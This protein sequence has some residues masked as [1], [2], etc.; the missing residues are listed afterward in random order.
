[1][2]IIRK[3]LGTLLTGVMASVVLMGT[4]ALAASP[5]GGVMPR[6]SGQDTG[7]YSKLEVSCN[8]E[9]ASVKYKN[10]AGKTCY[11]EVIGYLED[12]YGNE[13]PE[14]QALF[15]SGKISS[16]SSVADNVQRSDVF[17]VNSSGNIYNGES[18][19]SPRYERLN[20]TIRR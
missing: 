10:N 15:D 8:S 1:M 5:G 11:L 7:N 18:T 12:K 16:G 6:V 9:G 14:D 19:A 4:T 3:M 2:K 17:G 13:F 20:V